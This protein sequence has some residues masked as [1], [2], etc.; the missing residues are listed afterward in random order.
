MSFLRKFCLITKETGSSVLTSSEFDQAATASVVPL[1]CSVEQSAH[2]HIVASRMFLPS[3]SRIA[4]GMERHP[5]N[6][7][8]LAALLEFGCAIFFFHRTQIRKEGTGFWKVL[9]NIF[10]RMSKANLRR[11]AASP[12]RFL[13]KEGDNL[14]FHVDVLSFKA[15]KVRLRSSEV[16]GKFVIRPALWVSFPVDDSHPRLLPASP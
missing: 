11:R 5:F 10:N 16:P 9:Q 1:M 6:S 2:S 14:T 7:K 8:P 13:S 15:R 4:I 3:Q 12:G